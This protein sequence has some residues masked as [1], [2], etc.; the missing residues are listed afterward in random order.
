VI[1]MY[2]V[3]KEYV[4]GIEA[5]SDINL[6]VKKGEFLFITGASGAGKTTLLK[7]IFREE[8]QTRGQI[9]I[10]GL[11]IDRIRESYVPHLRRSIGFI[12]QDFKLLNTR[13]IFDNVALPLEILGFSKKEIRKRVA[14]VLRSVGLEHKANSYP[15][16]L[17]A[18]EQQRVAIARA[19]VNE[20]KI[21]LA[22]EPTGNLDPDLSTEIMD[23]FERMQI[24]GATVVVATHNRDILSRYQKRSIVLEKGKLLGEFTGGFTVLKSSDFTS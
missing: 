20:P 2:H 7:L 21:I 5:L 19:M 6:N 11:N 17:S 3:Y 12:F 1:E 13:S 14:Y 9:I 16:R 10:N 22:D 15:L 24:R 4:R 23:L 18:G 8:R